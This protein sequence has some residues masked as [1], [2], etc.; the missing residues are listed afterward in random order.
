MK[1]IK[2]TGGIGAGKSLA[3][4]V[5]KELGEAVIDADEV[6]RRF[7]ADKRYAAAAD[8]FGDAERLK[9]IEARSHPLIAAD[10]AAQCAV[11]EA[12]GKR[13]VFVLVP[14]LKRFAAEIRCDQAWAVTASEETRISRVCQ[15]RGMSAEE[16]GL[17][18]NNQA[19]DEEIIKAAD[20]VIKNNGTREEFIKKIKDAYNSLV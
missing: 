13:R 7:R 18:M 11:L 3:G 16:V 19:T 9:Q 5:L 2:I 20:V 14:A 15:T 8:I 10:I 4:E 12:Q 1:I 6:A 17:R